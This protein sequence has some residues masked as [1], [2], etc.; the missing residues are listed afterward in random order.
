MSLLNE[1]VIFIL[2][3]VGC[4]QADGLVVSHRLVV[5]GVQGLEEETTVL[6]QHLQGIIIETLL[7]YTLNLQR[8]HLLDQLLRGQR[9][10]IC[11]INIWREGV[12]RTLRGWLV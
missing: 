7:A 8:I 2:A 9:L 3:G 12:P 10:A 11:W 4:G 6:I 1:L 5:D